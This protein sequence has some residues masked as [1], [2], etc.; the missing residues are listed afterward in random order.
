MDLNLNLSLSKLY[1]MPKNLISPNELGVGFLL[2]NLSFIILMH[3]NRKLV[4]KNAP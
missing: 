4:T 2:E 1:F 3:A